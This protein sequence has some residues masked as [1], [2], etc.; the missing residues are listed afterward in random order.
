MRASRAKLAQLARAVKD[1]AVVDS[2]LR[3]AAVARAVRSFSQR[4]M[5]AGWHSMELHGVATHDFHDLD[6]DKILGEMRDTSRFTAGSV[7]RLAAIGALPGR[8]AG[9]SSDRH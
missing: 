1:A 3:H 9:F 8:R 7:S 5:G 6:W 2:T 4:P